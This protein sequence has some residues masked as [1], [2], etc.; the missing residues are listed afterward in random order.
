MSI[1]K[2][3]SLPRTNCLQGEQALISLNLN[4][5]LHWTIKN[6]AYTKMV[7]NHCWITIIP[8]SSMGITNWASPWIKKWQRMWYSTG[9]YKVLLQD[10]WKV[11]CW[12]LIKI[13]SLMRS[14][15]TL[16][17]VTT[18]AQRL[19]QSIRRGKSRFLYIRKSW[20]L[21]VLQSWDF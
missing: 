14:R 4:K 21:K 16:W 15:L 20:W 7:H 17:E 10:H 13:C 6:K 9:L 2:E 1:N 3:I 8:C 18:N 19:L 12:I 11:S 5:I